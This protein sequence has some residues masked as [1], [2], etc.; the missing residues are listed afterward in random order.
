VSQELRQC[1]ADVCVSKTAANAYKQAAKSKSQ[2]AQ[3]TDHQPLST[4]AAIAVADSAIRIS[5][6]PS[7]EAVHIVVSKCS[8]GSPG[9]RCSKVCVYGRTAWRK[10]PCHARRAITR[11][12]LPLVACVLLPLEGSASGFPMF[13]TGSNPGPPQGVS[14]D[15][16]CLPMVTPFSAGLRAPQGSPG[17]HTLLSKLTSQLNL[18]VYCR[19]ASATSVVVSPFQSSI[20]SMAPDGPGPPRV[21]AHM[22][23]EHVFFDKTA[24]STFL[25]DQLDRS[26]NDSGNAWSVGHVRDFYAGTGFF[27]GQGKRTKDRR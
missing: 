24:L 10:F 21:E 12:N 7:F 3:I 4:S 20:E 1:S 11:A 26:T 19:Q 16:S 9:P 25:P 13:P 17:I 2:R 6:S 27:S 8:P 22:R 23:A 5:E 14:P 15:W 18:V